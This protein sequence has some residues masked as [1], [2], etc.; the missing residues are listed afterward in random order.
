M[1]EK[2][3]AQGMAELALLDADIAKAWQEYG[4]PPPRSLTPHFVSLLSIVVSQQISTHAAKAIMTRVTALMPTVTPEHYLSLSEQSIREAG[5]SARKVLYTR[6]LAQAICDG[7]L[8]IEQL[9][10][11]DDAQAITKIMA[12]KGFG[13]WSAEIFL[14]FALTRTDVFPADDLA[15]QVALGRLKGLDEKPTAKEARTIVTAWA[16]WRTV[17]SLFLWHYYRGAP[18]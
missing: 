16:P 2:L 13:R 1:D 12:L 18:A 8:D 17:G 14:M 5:L 15:L 6:G 9:A 7:Q 10:T 4:N 3:I 11:L